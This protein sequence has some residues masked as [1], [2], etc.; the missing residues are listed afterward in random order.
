MAKTRL[1][2]A[3]LFDL[4]TKTLEG[5]N[6]FLIVLNKNLPAYA[7][8]E[9]RK[10]L[11]ANGASMH[12]LKNRVFLKALETNKAYQEAFDAYNFDKNISLVQAE[13]IIVALK[14]LDKMTESAKDILALQGKDEVFVKKYQ[15]YDLMAGVIQGA[16]VN[17]E[18]LTMLAELPGVDALYGMLAG[19]L[20]SLLTGLAG[21]LGGNIRNLA[22][23]LN[24]VV[25]TKQE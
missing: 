1:Q 8:N 7:I 11:K 22:Y 17:K 20:K 6:F 23:A 4:Y 18:D 13:D 12:L 25:E 3:K 14:G 2:K 21:A 9:Y 5:G 19:G 16:F 10:Y 24:Q 15:A